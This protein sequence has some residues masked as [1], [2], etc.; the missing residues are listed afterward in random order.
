M[1]LFVDA[2]RD[3]CLCNFALAVCIGEQIDIAC[4]LTVF[5]NEQI[6][7]LTSVESID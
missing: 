5:V 7:Q 2:I 3:Q 6:A 1:E 4:R